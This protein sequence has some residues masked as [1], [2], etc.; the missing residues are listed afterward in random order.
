MLF[1]C[2]FEFQVQ[3]CRTLLSI[4][5]VCI[6]AISTV[7]TR[8]KIDWSNPQSKNIRFFFWNVSITIVALIVFYGLV[9]ITVSVRNSTKLYILTAEEF[10]RLIRS[11][12]GV[13][14]VTSWS[15]WDSLF[16]VRLPATLLHFDLEQSWTSVWPLNSYRQQH[17]DYLLMTTSLHLIEE[18][19]V[20]IDGFL[21][22][23]TLCK[24]KILK[25]Y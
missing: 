7:T 13:S 23:E 11:C 6:K 14:V 17:L 15:S 5:D 21:M 20:N 12:F 22:R 2:Y 8:W 25:K 1:L 10:S 18:G 24:A 3:T 9:Q 16:L 19:R 4:R